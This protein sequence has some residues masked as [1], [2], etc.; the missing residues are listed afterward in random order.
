M[1]VLKDPSQPTIPS[2]YV[3]LPGVGTSISMFISGASGSYLSERAE[4]KK[5][6]AD[7]NM[8]MGII[9]NETI[10][11][12]FDIKRQEEELKK[13]MLSKIKIKVSKSENNQ[14]NVRKTLHEKA[15]KFAG[16][17]VALV[18]G[19]APLLGGLIPI[20]PFVFETNASFMTF[21]Y[22]FI[23]IFFCIVLLGIF[24]G[25]ISNESILKNVLQMLFAFIATMIVVIVFLG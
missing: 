20:I 10:E 22:S 12:E 5:K 2:L 16:K 1:V 24:L 8:A 21:I 25:R 23:V 13:A 3:A 14:P 19:F 4:L 11:E 17:F 9:E 18:N 6:R 15:H 7:L